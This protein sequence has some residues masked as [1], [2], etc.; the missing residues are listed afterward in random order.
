M[1]CPQARDKGLQM[2]DTVILSGKNE[3]RDY[4][5]ASRCHDRKTRKIIRSAAVFVGVITLLLGFSSTKSEMIIW[6]GAGVF[7]IIWGMFLSEL[8]YTRR[9]RK[10]W[11]NYPAIKDGLFTR[12]IS[13]D[14]ISGRIDNDTDVLTRWENF[15]NWKEG[16][17]VFLVYL[18]LKIYMIV[19]KRL[20]TKIPN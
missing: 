3:F 15:I 11:N 5:E 19:P 17:N 1:K 18:S 20:L 16:P 10:M 14:G 2:S 12:V 13:T 9:V 8:L 4:L 6:I 7:F